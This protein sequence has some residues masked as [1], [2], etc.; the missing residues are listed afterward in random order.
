V[1]ILLE[2]NQPIPDFLEGEKPEN[3]ELVFDDDTD[4][5]GE[6]NGN[7]AGAPADPWGAGKSGD[8]NTAGSESGN[9]AED[10][11]ATGAAW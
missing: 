8:N 6:D 9:N 2:C 11:E 10:P 4:N 5:E 3:E 1:K 7:E